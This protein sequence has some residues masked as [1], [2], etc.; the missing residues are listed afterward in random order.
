MS[1][2][3]TG[4]FVLSAT[5]IIVSLTMHAVVRRYVLATIVSA[6]VT[7]IVFQVLAYVHVGYL[8]PFFPI[9]VVVGWFYAGAIAGVVGIPFRLARKRRPPGHCQACGYNLTGNMSGTC[10]EC[11][12]GV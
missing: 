7:T 12:K 4:I 3:A 6:T 1:E 9:A 2:A 11:G 10:P 5:G 8:D